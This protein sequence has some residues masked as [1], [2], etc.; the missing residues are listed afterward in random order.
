MIRTLLIAAGL[1][2]LIA[3]ALTLG[4]IQS[5]I[6]IILALCAF[7]F[8]LSHLGIAAILGGMRREGGTP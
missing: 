3:A 2:E 6:Q 8:G 4:V 1:V 5:D 7:G